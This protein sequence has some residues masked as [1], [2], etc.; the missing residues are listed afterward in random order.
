[1]YLN[2]AIYSKNKLTALF[3]FPFNIIFKKRFNYDS[4]S[5]TLRFTNCVRASPFNKP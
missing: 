3:K 4:I 2:L 1:M 5:E